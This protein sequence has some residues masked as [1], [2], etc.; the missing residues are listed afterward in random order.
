M[1]TDFKGNAK[2]L[3]LKRRA[4]LLVFIFT[5]LFC[6]VSSVSA[7]VKNGQQIPERLFS[8]KL[9]T[10]TIPKLKDTV[11]TL[12]LQDTF[13]FKKSGDAIAAPVT[14]HADD[15]MVLDVPG[16]VLRLYGKTNELRYQD[17]E[18]KAPFIQYDQQDNLITAFMMVDS[19]GRIVARPSFNQ[20]GMKSVNDTILFNMKSMKGISKGS[21]TQQGEMF[22][23]G[24]QIKKVSDDVFF[25]RGSRFTTCNLDTPHF[26]FVSKKVKIIRNKVAVTGLVH[27]EFEGVP[28]PVGLPFGMFP[29][30]RGRHSGLMA[31][32]F[33][34]N[35]QLGMAL[36]GLGYYK[37]IN[38]YWDVIFRGT[39][40][41]YGGWAASVNPRY[42]KKYRY[43]GNLSFDMQQFKS[44]FKGDPDFVSS[45]TFNLRW[46]HSADA[47]SRPGVSFSANVNAG[48]SR[49]NE[50]VPNNPGLNFTNQL[51]SSITYAKVWKDKP[52]NLSVSA[53]H[54]QNTAQRL[55][56]VN[57]PDVN[58]NVNTLYP[59]R[60]KEPVG[61]SKWYENL[62]IALNSNARSLTSFYDTA[63][64]MGRQISDRWQ[65]GATHNVPVNLSLPPLGV[66]QI[67][68]G[69]SYSQRWYQRKTVRQWNE[70][71]GKLDTLQRDGFYAAHDMSFSLGMTSRIFGMFTFGKNAGVEAIR[72]E[73]R[74]TLSVS[75]K[76]DINKKFFYSTQLDTAGNRGRYN[77]FEGSVF[78]AFGEGKF[79]G[80]N[81]GIDNNLQM[82]LRN[83]NDTAAGAGRKISLIDGFAVGGSYNFL[84]DSFQLSTFNMTARSSLFEKIHLTANALF[85]PYQVNETGRR[86]NKL[87]WE[88][89]LLSLGT[90]TGGSISLSSN[91]RGGEKGKPGA[92]S[93]EVYRRYFS[94]DE[95]RS[96]LEYMAANPSEFVDFS[97]PWNLDFSYSL[98][99][100]RFRT[101]TDIRS[102][103]TQDVNWNASVNL[104][105]RWKVG[106][107]G[108]YNITRK[109]LGTISMSMSRE[110]HCWQMNIT[111]SPVGLYKFFSIN[112]SPKSGMLSDL[113][114]NRTRYFYGL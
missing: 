91:L 101:G 38:D 18:L 46:S 111:V 33:T 49:F 40:Y 105:E 24:K 59:F 17:Q 28:L 86:I 78:G 56:N 90:L 9:P 67:S 97:V 44:G 4:L 92:R 14:Y 39:V 25:A 31:P 16:K 37:I 36:E 93:G 75:Y 95:Y 98:R 61:E 41:S 35:Q 11:T 1:P 8:K 48:S 74:P 69:M 83:K 99:I 54:N 22:V 47:K 60:R 23:Y 57:L 103:L 21:Y 52:F 100:S 32:T 68:P 104:T 7:A 30:T 80:L 87:V 53:N 58:F 109:E 76:P 3:F 26:A 84:L 82:K 96:E 113:R 106:V 110:L 45:Q 88:D 73:I 94:S 10:D 27:P 29:M 64:D 43:Q 71:A 102:Q 77:V 13:R 50:Q 6:F 114:I 85:D 79:G 62:G 72:H 70:A 63:S 51:S 55:I 42:F 5:F 12:Q 107:N 112:I 2:T 20:G 34:A 15:S 81:F 89:K 108:F 19:N 65:W 66:L